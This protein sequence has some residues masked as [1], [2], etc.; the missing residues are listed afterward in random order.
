MNLS[1]VGWIVVALVAMSMAG[2]YALFW[3]SDALSLRGLATAREEQ[4]GRI[5]WV[6]VSLTFIGIS[7]VL[8]G[9]SQLSMSPRVVAAIAVVFSIS[10]LNCASIL[11]RSYHPGWWPEWWPW[12]L[13][14]DVLALL[15]VLTSGTVAGF[16]TTRVLVRSLE[17]RRSSRSVVAAGGWVICSLLVVFAIWAVL[18]LE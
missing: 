14:T 2:G 6:V 10:V 15:S 4:I 9:R 5:L 1:R 8:G 17:G 7:S 16:L 13:T 11:V 3:A 18:Y 12:V